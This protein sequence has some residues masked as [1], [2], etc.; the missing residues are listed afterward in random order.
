MGRR[1][2]LHEELVALA[3][4][5]FTVYFQPPEGTEIEYPCVIYERDDG[6]AYYADNRVY[7]YMQRYQVSVITRDADCDLPEAILHYFPLCRMD[8]PF[9][10]DNLYHN[11][12][13][14]YY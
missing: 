14:L 11:T 3:G 1:L 4:S 6:D 2:S 5:S 7:R 8:R 9:V 10:T 12:L 13:S